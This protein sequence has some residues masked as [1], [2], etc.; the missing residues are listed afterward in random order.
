MK[1]SWLFILFIGVILTLS[2]SLT[3]KTTV[4][5]ETAVESGVRNKI[6]HSA[7][8][9]LGAPYKYGGTDRNGYDCSGLMFDVF[10][11]VNI[12]LPRTSV[13]QSRHG[14]RIAWNKANIGDLIFFNQKGKINH[15]AVV[16]KKSR[17]EVWVV[18][19]T[20][21]RGVITEDLNS[22]TYWKPRIVGARDVISR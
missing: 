7:E 15:V 18:H 13:D 6:A 17:G 5:N 9:Y 12:M 1:E 14:K 3:K 10:Q 21:S 20:T 11:T 19:S 16:T 22:S 2:C 4:K 8:K